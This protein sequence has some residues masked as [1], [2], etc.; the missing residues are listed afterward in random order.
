MGLIE[1]RGGTL[2]VKDLDRLAKMVHEAS[3]E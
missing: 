1:R 2:L 3:G